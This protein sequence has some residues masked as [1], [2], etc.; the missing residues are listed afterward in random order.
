VKATIGAI[1]DEIVGGL[2]T[3][4]NSGYLS[5]LLRSVGVEVETFFAVPDDVERIREALRRALSEADLVVTTGGL[6]PTADDLTTA[7]AAAV[8][9]TS[10][11]LHE[12]SLRS[13]EERFRDRGVEMPENNRKQA[14]FPRGAVVIPNPDGTAPGFVVEVKEGERT[15]HLVSLPGVP[16]E[17]RRMAEETLIPWVAARAGG[18]RFGSR[19]FSTFGLSESRL[20]ELL[21]GAIDPAEARLSFRAAFP[22]LQVRVSVSAP[23]DAEVEG[24]LDLL[25]ARV[26]ERLGT[27]IY[28]VGDEGLEETVGGLLRSRGE[29]L[30]LAESCT[31]GLIGHRLT[32]VAGSS[33]YL[34]LGVVA[35]SNE[36]KRSMLG[37]SEDTLRL[38]GAVSEETVLEMARGA[39]RAAGTDWG[40][41]TSGIAGPGGGTEEKPVGTVCIAAVGGGGEWSK[42]Y[43]LGSRSRGWVKE[44][45]AQIA[46]DQL[47]RLLLEA[48]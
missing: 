26:R 10:L 33:E 15:A 3:D 1:G 38:H 43:Q 35:Y 23:T 27:S 45:T 16:R 37:V 7:C 12:A 47:R 5:Q 30:A 40:L 42:R 44:M 39:R 46:L 14:L 48:E 8:A 13:I 18:G 21:T 17:M 22:R 11:E 4:T 41:A 2:T 19:I 32:D 9:G 31:G 25:E 29:T 34:M 6:G 20:D 28:A 24:R 36:A